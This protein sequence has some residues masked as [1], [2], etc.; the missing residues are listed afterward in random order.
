MFPFGIN[1]CE[2]V[3]LRGTQ[4]MDK[5]YVVSRLFSGSTLTKNLALKKGCG[6]FRIPIFD[7]WIFNFYGSGSSFKK[8][9]PVTFIQITKFFWPW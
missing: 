8:R 2:F 6:S 5:T 1:P 9:K 7:L 3:E 4:E